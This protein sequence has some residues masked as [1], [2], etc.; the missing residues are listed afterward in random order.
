MIKMINVLIEATTLLDML[1]DRVEYLTTD[2]DTREL[3][4][5]YYR[6]QIENGGFEGCELDINVTVDNDYVNYFRVMEKDDPDYEWALENPDRIYGQLDNG[7]I[8]VYMA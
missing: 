5:N 2:S 7:T 6:E 1:T 4:E 8:L 3:F